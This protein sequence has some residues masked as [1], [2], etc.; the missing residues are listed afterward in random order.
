MRRCLRR[1]LRISDDLLLQ[2]AWHFLVMRGLHVEAA[3]A[4]CNGPSVE[5]AAL[6]AGAAVAVSSCSQTWYSATWSGKHGWIAYRDLKPAKSRQQR[7]PAATRNSDGICVP[8]P[9]L[10]PIPP[11]GSP[12]RNATM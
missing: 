4:L 5:L 2:A 9:Q 10:S 6:P 3:A 8:S 11:P 12:R 7:P 1:L